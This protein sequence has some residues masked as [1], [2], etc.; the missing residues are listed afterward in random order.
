VSTAL[1]GTAVALTATP[2][3]A[4]AQGPAAT[5]AHAPTASEGRLPFFVGERLTYRVHSR[6]FGAVG[7]LSMLVDTAESVRGTSAWVLRFDFRARVGPMKAVDRTESWLDPASLTALRFHKHERTPLA[8]H[9]ERVEI[10]PAAHRWTAEHGAGGPI[11]SDAPLDEL[12]FMY[13]L[14]TL[15]LGTEADSAVRHARHFDAARNPTFLRLVERR[16][17]TTAAG[18]FRTLLVEMRVQDPRRFRGEGVI[19]LDLTDD[20]CRIPV[21]IESDM[22]VIGRTRMT[23]ATQNHPAAHHVAAVP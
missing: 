11:T 9:D 8:K 16:S 3:A 13:V 4:P 19:R 20:A 18:T 21:Q 2:G 15:P 10:D 12:S 17:V 6:R 14:R 23:L 22:P 7:R 1:L 5:T